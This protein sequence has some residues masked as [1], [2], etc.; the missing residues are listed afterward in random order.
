VAICLR[1]T[2]DGTQ[3]H[4][5]NHQFDRNALDLIEETIH[6]YYGAEAD[7][8]SDWQ[9]VEYYLALK[10]GPKKTAAF[11]KENRS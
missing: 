8:L 5:T 4:L 10:I 1:R 6:H 9:S 11:I 3:K 2:A 7:T